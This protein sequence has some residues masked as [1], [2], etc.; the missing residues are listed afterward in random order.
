MKTK[1]QVQIETQIQVYRERY[2]YNAERDI[3][4]GKDRNIDTDNNKH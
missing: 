2:L 1:M 3:D 4:T